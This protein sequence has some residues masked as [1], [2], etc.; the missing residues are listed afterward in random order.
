MK[1]LSFKALAVAASLTISGGA[2]AATLTPLNL[3]GGWDS[4]AYRDVGNS[5]IAS[6][7]TF[8]FTLTGHALLTLVD[9]YLSGD[10]FELISNGVSRG[11]TSQGTPGSKIGNKWDQAMLDSAFSKRSFKF[12]P[13]TY[14]VSILV[15]RQFG[16]LGPNRNLGI[17]L[18][19]AP[20][21]VPA[22][23]ALLLSALGVA[24]AVRRR[25]AK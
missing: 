3:D 15:D 18:D 2:S 4:T 13:G 11:F 16:P 6:F 5:V 10:R 21:P 25:R 1:I 20:V 22:A 8:S 19:T 9:G 7:R 24:A 17:R 12:G 14:A 23:G